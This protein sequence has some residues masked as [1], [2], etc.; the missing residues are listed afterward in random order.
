[1]SLRASLL[2]RARARG[3]RVVL[4]EGNDPRVQAAAA[5]LRS[6]G[7]AEPILLGA[8][9]LEPAEDPR[10]G[11]IAELLRSRR[12]DRVEDGIHALDLAA[13]PLRFGAGLVA[14]GEADACVAGVAHPTA[15]VLR[16]ALWAIG[17]APGASDPTRPGSAAQ[18]WVHD[19]LWAASW[20]AQQK[21][22]SEKGSGHGIDV[23]S[24]VFG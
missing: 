21:S 24:W 23:H 9:H 20:R 14:L 11:A 5:R 12:P 4:A 18:V 6:E 22:R 15:E 2:E 3:G 13:D 10:L 7:I 1:V 17:L 19:G 8:G 16:A